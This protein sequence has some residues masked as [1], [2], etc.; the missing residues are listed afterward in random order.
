MYGEYVALNFG[1][2]PSG[3]CS[4]DDVCICN[5]GYSGIY[6]LNDDVNNCF[7]NPGCDPENS[8]FCEDTGK[9]DDVSAEERFRCDCKTHLGWS[10]TYCD[11][12]ADDCPG[13]SCANGATCN[14]LL[15]DY[16]CTCL[17]GWTG[18]FCDQ[19]IDECTEG[20][21]ETERKRGEKKK[22][23]MTERKKER[24]KRARKKEGKRERERKKK[25]NSERGEIK[26]ERIKRIEEERKEFL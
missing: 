11:E 19:D 12:D 22:E 1:L 15:G 9:G 10:G 4:P 7:P 6:C 8:F 2:N 25:K 13:H 23:R 16:S 14:D 26:I 5:S 24:K 3:T 20:K 21:L 18:Y 17:P